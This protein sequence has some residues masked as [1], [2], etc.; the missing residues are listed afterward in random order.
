M[1]GLALISGSKVGFYQ[2]D[3]AKLTE[4]CVLLKPTIFPSVPRLYNKIYSSLKS[5]IGLATGCK[6]W[7]V[8]KALASKAAGLKAN[9]S[10]HSACYDK[11]VFSKMAAALG[12]CCE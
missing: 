6:A 9:A 3:P 8:N 2:G 4:D 12:G 1:F 5:K 10:Y 11:L 7:L